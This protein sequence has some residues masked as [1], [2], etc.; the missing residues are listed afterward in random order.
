[1]SMRPFVCAPVAAL[2]VLAACGGSAARPV[3]ATA[4][5]PAHSPPPAAA[6]APPAP[7]E[8][9]GAGGGRRRTPT[10]ILPPTRALLAGLMPL[11]SG[12]VDEF[13][14]KHPS[15]DGRGAL[16]GLLASRVDTGVAGV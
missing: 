7:A 11:H 5:Q 9:G 16:R 13:R 15:H 8:R 4:P 14:A 10:P 3:T 6:P 12:R 2:A 1:M